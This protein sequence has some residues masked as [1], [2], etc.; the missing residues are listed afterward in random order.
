MVCPIAETCGNGSK[1]ICV[2]FHIHPATSD[3]EGTCIYH[4][5]AGICQPVDY[6]VVKKEKAL[7]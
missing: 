2:H 3:C 6:V 5:S 1:R 4:D 7:P